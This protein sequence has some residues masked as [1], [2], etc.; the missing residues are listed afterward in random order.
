MGGRPARGP[1][2][3]RGHRHGRARQR[4]LRALGARLGRGLRSV[5]RVHRDSALAASGRPGD[6]R[7]GRQREPAA[8]AWRLRC[9]R[10]GAR[11]ELLPGSGGRH[12]GTTRHRTSRGPG[13]SVRLG[14]RRGHGAPLALLGCRGRNL[15]AGIRRGR[16]AAL[17][18]LRGRVARGGLRVGRSGP[19]SRDGVERIDPVHRLRRLLAPVPGRNRVLPPASCPA[20]RRSGRSPWRTSSAPGCRACPTGASHF[21]H[22]R[23]P[24]SVFVREVPGSR[25]PP[26]P[27]WR[28][29]AP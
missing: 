14:L 23:G 20:S 15:G 11:P 9:G 7:G 22:E 4:D 8:P 12:P 26:H 18:D 10:V 13:G 28:L 3:R 29:A 25:A 21:G 5:H 17:P 27:W 2:A 1:L 24:W 19:R 16:E 6:L